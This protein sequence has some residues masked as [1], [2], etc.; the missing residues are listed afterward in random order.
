MPDF[1]PE[2]LLTNPP[3]PV[4]R[5]LPETLVNRIAAGEVIERPAAVVKEL[6][7]NALD[8]GA[9]QIEVTLR[10]GGRSEIIVTDDGCGMDRANL[11]L[12]I[13]RHATSKLHDDQ[14]V[15]INTLGFRG[16]ALPSIGAVARLTLISRPQKDDHA[17]S[18]SIHGGT[19][20]EP[21][22]AARAPGTTII[23]R[24]LFYATPARLK[25]LKS[26]R[27]E[28]HQALDVLRRLALSHHDIGFS[29][30]IDDRMA[31]R[32]APTKDVQNRVF[33]V[34]G[35]D[36]VD[37]MIALDGQRDNI[38]IRGLAGLPTHH[39]PTANDQYLFVNNRPIRD[40]QILG[41]LKAAYRDFLPHDRHPVVVLFLDLP[42]QEIDVNV[43]PAKTDIRF[44]DY[45][46]V[47]GAIITLIQQSLASAG[48]RT[49]NMGGIRAINAFSAPL[50]PAP[51][52]QDHSGWDTP[53]P[54]SEPAQQGFGD[55]MNL[56][57]PVARNPVAA[58]IAPTPPAEKNPQNFPLGAAVA[59]IHNTY[60]I[61]QTTDGL[62]V[63]DQH[64]AHERLIY[65]Q[66]KAAL[67][68]DGV[69]AQ[70]LL[71]PE[72]IELSPLAAGELVAAQDQLL[73]LGLALEAFGPSAVILRAV[74]VLL[75]KS[76]WQALVRDLADRLIE[77]GDAGFLTE[78]L[79]HV[80]ATMACHG[81]IRAG[82]TMT[83]D[84]MNR[85]LRDM[86]RTP[87]SGQCN[88]GRPTSVALS[89]SQ[90]ERLFGRS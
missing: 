48:H 34:L 10:D 60:I 19:R 37:N 59:Q 21:I 80:C 74:P 69:P 84:E 41:A 57:L 71:I 13:E 4:I 26:P 36:L 17:W 47:R 51:I 83:I 25:F 18:L 12:A 8:A 55:A 45:Q 85:L 66:I 7:E 88:H 73:R 90:I 65:E 40:R 56:W 16:E 42:A 43:H 82:R 39:R 79:Y 50:N 46:Q 14:L 89:L 15:K 77:D 11:L 58:S 54:P 33:D 49:S 62:V 30:R 22:P 78:K 53:P 27:T 44:R 64:A 29:A 38:R 20:E 23:V 24:D 32:L 9:R 75:G 5:R 35:R 28:N 6:V 2:H 1:A 68:R 52:Y 61:A 81:S 76:D 72:V 67:D 70:N 86:E 3:T 87:G 31:L 63:V